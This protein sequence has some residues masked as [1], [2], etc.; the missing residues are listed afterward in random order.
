MR[1]SRKDGSLRSKGMVERGKAD[2][3]GISGIW[4]LGLLLVEKLKVFLINQVDKSRMYNLLPKPSLRPSSQSL[5]NR[6]FNVK[7]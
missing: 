6:N 1:G 4:G 5:I 3:V 7:I 2:K